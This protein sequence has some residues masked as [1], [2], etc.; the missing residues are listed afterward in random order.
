MVRPRAREFYGS[1]LR[2]L[3]EGG[4]PLVVGGA[5]A[6]KFYAGINRDTKDLDL[7][8][9]ERDVSPAR[10]VLE[11][12]G[13]RTELTFPHWLGKA[14]SEEHFVDMI[15]SSANGLCPV[16]DAWFEHAVKCTLFGVPVLLCPI[17]EVIW[18]KGF[19]MER[20]RF[21][22]AD[23]C[24]LVES[25]GEAIDWRRL[26][27]RFDGHWRVL[28]GHLAFFDFV[29]PGSRHKVPSWVMGELSARLA[30]EHATETPGLCRGTL[31][32]REQYL[33]DLRERAYADARVPPFGRVAPEQIAHWT[34]AIGKIK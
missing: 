34:D 28:L 27:D 30:S 21:D 10:E 23:I 14:W 4:V 9:R 22:G 11:S 16:D 33:V 2:A 25:R 17:E 32:S 3:A 19:V 7:F 13:F 29:Y 1:T 15:F 6:L 26:V 20:E 8:V 12:A 5:F 31:V 24:H 18:T